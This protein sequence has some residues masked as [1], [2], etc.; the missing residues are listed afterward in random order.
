MD[1]MHIIYFGYPYTHNPKLMTEEIKTLVVSLLD[2][3]AKVR[4]EFDIVPIV[5]HI[6]FDG[7]YD[8]PEGYSN[9]FM[10]GWEFEIIS[11]A[12]GICFPET[13]IM[14]YGCAW[15]LQ[16]AKWFGVD[17]FNYNKLYEGLD[18]E[19]CVI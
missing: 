16:F 14:S 8:Y 18:I 15:E 1:N 19:L 9:F 13:D 4:D 10:L 3:R 6:A 5:P 7:L 2:H 12:R 11:V 17:I